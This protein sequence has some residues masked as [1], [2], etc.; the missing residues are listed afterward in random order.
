[1]HRGWVHAKGFVGADSSASTLENTN[2]ARTL[3]SC[4]TARHFEEDL[5]ASVR[6]IVQRQAE[7]ARRNGDQIKAL[8]ETARATGKAS[9]EL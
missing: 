6:A 5:P 4:A 3:L 1:M 2:A 9:S 8:R 7:G